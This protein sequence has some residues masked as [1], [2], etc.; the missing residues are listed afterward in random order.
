MER[1]GI[2]IVVSIGRLKEM[3]CW[4]ILG[5]LTNG[6]KRV[7]TPSVII[8]LSCQTERKGILIIVSIGYLEKSCIG[9]YW[10]T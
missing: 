10:V 5:N 3:V 4:W 8:G 7:S 1:K 9:V 6:M 2:S